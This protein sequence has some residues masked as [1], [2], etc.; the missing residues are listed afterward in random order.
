MTP[1][2]WACM[3]LR[4]TLEMGIFGRET[5]LREEDTFIFGH[6]VCGIT[7]ERPEP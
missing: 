6:E 3:C 5:N 4:H 2:H 1:R 7:T